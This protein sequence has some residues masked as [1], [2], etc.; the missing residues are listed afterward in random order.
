MISKSFCFKKLNG[1]VF[2]GYSQNMGANEDYYS[3]STPAL[4][5]ARGE[6][7]DHILRVSPRI[8]YTS[9]KMTLILEHMFSSAVYGTTFD[10]KQKATDRILTSPILTPVSP[11]GTGV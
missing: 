5:Y 1:G 8:Q 10:S 11:R 6:T 9:G 7:I 4:A 3:L 2:F